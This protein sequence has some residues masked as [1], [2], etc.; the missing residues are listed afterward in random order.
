MK[1]LLSLALAIV[2]LATCKCQGFLFKIMEII[3]DI[4]ASFCAIGV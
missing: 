4:S 1:K 3:Y 2:M